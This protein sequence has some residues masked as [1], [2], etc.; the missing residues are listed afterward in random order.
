MEPATHKVFG[1]L[2]I[3]FAD[4]A[5]RRHVRPQRIPKLMGGAPKPNRELARAITADIPI[6][7]RIEASSVRFKTAINRSRLQQLLRGRRA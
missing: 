7:R 6:G 4:I 5:G 1:Q 3:T 2:R